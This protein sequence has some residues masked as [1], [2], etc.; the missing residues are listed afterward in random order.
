MKFL[1]IVLLI[2][3]LLCLG[4]IYLLLTHAVNLNEDWRTAN[5]QSAYLAPDPLQEQAAI[6]QVYAA[7]A[8][9]WRGLFA[10]HTWIAVKPEHAKH[11]TVYQVV[12]WYMFQRQPVMSIKQDIP[13]RYWYANK[14]TIIKDIR[15]GV[16]ESLI[17]RID[18]AARAYPYSQQYSL[19]PGPNSNT[20]IAYIARAVP[21]LKLLLPATAIGK[22]YLGRGIHWSKTPSGTGYQL[23]LA[24][25][26]GI[27]LA[28]EE[29]LEINLLGLTLGI[30]PG[31]LGLN[32]PGI[33]I[34]NFN[35][36]S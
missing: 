22:D 12:G 5:R 6:I 7:R 18:Q 3:L 19:W 33:G 32:L 31:Q 36:K 13:D 20:F 16:A 28:R 8:F 26:F 27:S 9:N 23:S 24:G 29:G 21:E 1:L 11:Y 10:V 30:M 25:L 4:P 34:V 14:P 17:K 2:L 15:G 35:G